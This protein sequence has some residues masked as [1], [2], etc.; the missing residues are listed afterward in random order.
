MGEDTVILKNAARPT[1]LVHTLQEA[2]KPHKKEKKE[3]D[4]EP[5]DI[6]VDTLSDVVKWHLVTGGKNYITRDYVEKLDDTL[7]QGES[8]D[9]RTKEEKI[10]IEEWKERYQ[11]DAPQDE[12]DEHSK[13]HP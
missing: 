8:I 2:I 3:E 11:K 4:K 1:T 7:T 13:T 9:L 6:L 12:W 5:F 10:I